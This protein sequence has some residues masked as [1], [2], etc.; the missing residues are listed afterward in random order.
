MNDA[1]F[2]NRILKLMDRATESGYVIDYPLLVEIG[3]R[4]NWKI[5]K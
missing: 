1:E 5:R 2:Y 4:M 3:N